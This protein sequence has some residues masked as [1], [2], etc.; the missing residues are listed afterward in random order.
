MSNVNGLTRLA[1]CA[2][3]AGLAATPALAQTKSQP[4]SRF[5]T[6]VNH[7]AQKLA[8]P[9]VKVNTPAAVTSVRG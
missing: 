2:A 7:Q 6:Y 4:Q 8:T 3:L 1:L 5:W 9:P